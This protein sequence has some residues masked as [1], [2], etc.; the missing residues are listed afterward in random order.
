MS[1]VIPKV[2]EDMEGGAANCLK[3]I[4]INI[5]KLYKP[6]HKKQQENHTKVH[7]LIA[8]SQWEGENVNT[9]EKNSKTV[10]LE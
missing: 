10:S 3:P 4:H 2:I 5:K 8:H 7:N 6:K 1:F 9:R